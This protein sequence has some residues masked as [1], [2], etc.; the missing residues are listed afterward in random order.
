MSI[1]DL[2]AQG[3]LVREASHVL[4]QASNEQRCAV[5]R[6]VADQFEDVEDELLAGRDATDLR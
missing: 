1:V 3:R 5:L 6:S 4:A 2:E